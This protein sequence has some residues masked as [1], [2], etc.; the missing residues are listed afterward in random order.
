MKPLDRA[1]FDAGVCSSLDIHFGRFISRLSRTGGDDIFLA[2]ALASSANRQGHICLDLPRLAGTPLTEETDGGEQ[3]KHPETD[4]WR[5]ALASA[6][7]IGKPGDATPLILDD[8]SRLYLYRYWDYQQR[9]A[10]F[11][12]HRTARPSGDVDPGRLKEGLTRLFP[13]QAAEKDGPD[14][15]SV[16]A[17][18]AVR[19]RFCIISGGPGTGKTTTVA[20]ILCLLL[21]QHPDKKPRIALA[22]PTG[23]AAARLS[24]SIRRAKAAPPE[25]PGFLNS[26][27][28]V[29]SAIPEQA[30]TIHRL[31]GGIPGSPY[32]RRNADYPLPFDVIVVDEASMVDL[33]LM[34]K[35]V[36]AV[37]EPARLILLGDKDQLSSVEAGAVLGDICE[38]RYVWNFST[39]F[40][41]EFKS[42]TGR[43]VVSASDPE[44]SHGLWDAAVQLRRSY[45]FGRDS[46]I[47]AV[48]RA[49][50]A[51]DGA[52]AVQILR[53]GTH[54]D[55]SW[56]DIP[57]PEALARRIR[58]RI[59]DGFSAYLRAETPVE[60]FL[61][62]DRF[63]ILCAVKQGPFG[64]R[65]LNRLAARILSSEN[66]IRPTRA[67][68]PGRPVMIAR[69]DYNLGLFNGDVGIVP[70][71]GAEEGVCFPS[72]QGGF[73][74]VHPLRLPEHDTVFA[75]TVHKSQ[76]S[77]FDDVLLLLPDRDAPVLTRELI[78]TGVTRARRGA[79]IWGDR[80]IFYRA[81]ERRVIR[82]SGL[83]DALAP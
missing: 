18:A 58:D 54:A 45:R 13:D 65:A 51:G 63:R 32:F 20:K 79:E 75:M 38:D 42:M 14:W 60:M 27:E 83:R 31:L 50:N 76:G 7:T 72:L 71:Y 53:Q 49:V 29:T 24:E 37:P 70:P 30:A 6:P 22:A 61:A 43:D 47:R 34:A 25:A 81:A 19:Q 78:Y 48:S 56:T 15:Q 23:K 73:R 44:T 12:R 9:L 67:W 41:A 26:S 1:L 10:A 66:L 55:I 39:P 77:E 3:I 74:T 17:Y 2:A 33:A 62:F 5:R 46:G 59:I 4:A 80:R 8:Q 64:V 57:R 82:S 28:S 68:Y 21:E 36:S 40:C 35:L 52:G 16:A 11:I 69:N